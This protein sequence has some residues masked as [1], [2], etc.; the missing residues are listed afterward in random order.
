MANLRSRIEKLEQKHS[1]LK[2]LIIINAPGPDGD[3]AAFETEL[4]EACKTDLRVIVVSES[5]LD[6]GQFSSRV[7]VMCEILALFERLA[8]NPPIGFWETLSGEILGVTS[9]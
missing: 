4:T 8:R 7:E 5:Q 6:L 3:W 1:D 9:S 2:S